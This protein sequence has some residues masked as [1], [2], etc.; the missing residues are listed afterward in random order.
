[1]RDERSRED[2]RRSTEKYRKIRGICRRTG[3]RGPGE[4]ERHP[5]EKL[6]DPW[7]ILDRNWEIEADP[8]KIEGD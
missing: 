8:A 5:W 3:V 4:I 1:M 7:E 6:E 2:T